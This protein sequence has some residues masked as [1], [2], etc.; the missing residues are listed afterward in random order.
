MSLCRRTGGSPRG[1]GSGALRPAARREGKYD[2]ADSSPQR[3]LSPGSPSASRPAGSQTGGRCPPA[4]ATPHSSL[5]IPGTE[6]KT[7]PGRGAPPTGRGAGEGRC[8]PGK[9]PVSLPPLG[10]RPLKSLFNRK[11]TGHPNS[12]PGYIW[13]HVRS[14]LTFRN[15]LYKMCT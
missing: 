14:H 1:P 4:T 7:A 15:I 13:I 9:R 10:A 3:P 8:C 11:Q 6:S 12:S 5:R 2:V